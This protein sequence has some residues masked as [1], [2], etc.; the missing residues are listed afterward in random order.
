MLGL[1]GVWWARA[2]DPA[3]AWTRLRL[4]GRLVGTPQLASDTPLEYGRRL[5]IRFPAL[6]DSLSQLAQARSLQLFA[7]AGPG[8]DW[9]DGWRL[10][11]RSLPAAVMR[12]R[13]R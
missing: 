4:A 3:A 9:R 7:P 11:R 1:A 5:G 10:A 6:A 2:G 13:R 12:L 8:E